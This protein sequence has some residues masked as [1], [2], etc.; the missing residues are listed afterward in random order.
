M[1]NYINNSLS[2]LVLID[3]NSKNSNNKQYIDNILNFNFCNYDKAIANITNIYEEYKNNILKNLVININNLFEINNEYKLARFENLQN[4]LIN[5]YSNIVINHY[6]H[7][8]IWFKSYLEKFKYEYNTSNRELE[9]FESYIHR[10]YNYYIHSALVNY[11]IDLNNTELLIEKDEWKL[12]R[13]TLIS[14]I[15]KYK[16]HKSF[17]EN[18]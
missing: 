6:K 9:N 12:K 11:T 7:I 17:F 4:Y 16:K 1:N 14:S 3:F 10:N 18:L 5:E 15:N 13:K 8:D 2:Q